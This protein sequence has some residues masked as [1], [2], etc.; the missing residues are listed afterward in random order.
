MLIAFL[1]NNLQA[2]GSLRIREALRRYMG[3]RTSSFR[4][5]KQ[6]KAAEAR[7][8]TAVRR[9]FCAQIRAANRAQTVFRFFRTP[10]EKLFLRICGKA[11]KHNGLYESM[12]IALARSF[13]RTAF[14][15]NMRNFRTAGW[16]G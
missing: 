8:E 15:A 7:C 5:S 12:Y 16:Q 3:A 14:L 13:H 1:A 9:P 6:A 10:C 4:R 11:G 2:D